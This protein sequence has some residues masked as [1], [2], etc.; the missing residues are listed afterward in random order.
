MW[1]V[2]GYFWHHSRPV[3]GTLDGHTLP[4]TQ[5]LRGTKEMAIQTAAGA[6]DEVGG[7]DRGLVLSQALIMQ[8]VEQSLAVSCG[9]CIPPSHSRRALDASRDGAFAHIAAG[10]PR[11]P[12]AAGSQSSFASPRPQARW[13]QTR[14]S[15][16][17]LMRPRDVALGRR[18]MGPFSTLRARHHPSRP[19]RIP[20]ALQ[21]LCAAARCKPSLVASRMADG[22]DD[23]AAGFVVRASASRSFFESCLQTTP[24]GRGRLLPHRLLLRPRRTRPRHRGRARRS[25][26]LRRYLPSGA[27]QCNLPV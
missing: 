11:R 6:G 26:T 1:I 2:P 20:C 4:V 3:A 16:S 27:S 25:T 7:E 22:P 13:S 12:F 18:R 10:L 23:F 24:L 15:T 8:S 19:T 17:V 9:T 21:P 14:F 5:R